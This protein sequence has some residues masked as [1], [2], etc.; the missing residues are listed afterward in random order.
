MAAKKPATTKAEEVAPPAKKPVVEPRGTSVPVGGIAIS[1]KD[2]AV[3]AQPI[4][5]R[6]K[7]LLKDHK[8][9]GAR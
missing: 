7:A 1:D 6:M 5:A 8:E 3:L 9:M 2:A 4:D